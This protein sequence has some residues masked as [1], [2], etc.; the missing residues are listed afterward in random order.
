MKSLVS[1]A[2]LFALAAFSAHSAAANAYVTPV[3][4]ET[5]ARPVQVF[6]VRQ[7][8]VVVLLPNTQEMQEE[9][10][11]W[12]QAVESLSKQAKVEPKDGIVV[13]IPLQEPV[14]IKPEISADRAEEIY[15]FISQN[16]SAPAKM[17]VFTQKSQPL[18]VNAQVN[19]TPFLRKHGL[20]RYMNTE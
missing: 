19:L 20:N 15:V 10:K 2:A 13:R 9:A 16:S 5:Y 17:L 8:K 11:T 6:D 3:T 1:S 12:I 14:A 4:T 18:L 7:G